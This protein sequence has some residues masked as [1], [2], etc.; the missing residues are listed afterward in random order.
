MSHV[1]RRCGSVV[2]VVAAMAAMAATT[3][4]SFAVTPTPTATPTPT[5]APEIMLGV[6]SHLASSR[7]TESSGI[8]A[9]Y[10][11]PDMAYTLNDNSED[12]QTVYSFRISTGELLG[13]TE[14]PYKK[15][16]DTE[17]I[18][19]DPKG[20]VWVGDLGDNDHERTNAS[21][22]RFTEP[23]PGNRTATGLVRFP[24][25]YSNGKPNV[26]AMLVNPVNDQ[27]FLIDK[28]SSGAASLYRLPTTLVANSPN[29]AKPTYVSMPAKVSDA[30]ISRDGRTAIVRTAENVQ[31]F[32]T[33][34]WSRYA[35]FD[36]P[37]LS[38]PESVTIEPGQTTFLFGSEGSNSPVYRYPIPS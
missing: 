38:K 18:Y 35:V 28:R 11:Y 16:G 17:S 15:R 32:R 8:A 3:T 2:V 20:R 9:S 13:R 31:F 23:G 34:L 22:I 36:V 26:E 21:I 1:L 4:S 33:H 5:Y 29:V 12:R 37:D 30:V 25:R 19:A 24:V 7:I 27:V 6:V 10:T 14:L